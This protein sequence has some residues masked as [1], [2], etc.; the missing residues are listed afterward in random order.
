MD[1]LFTDGSIVN[2]LFNVGLGE[3]QISTFNSDLR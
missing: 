3:A 1:N 2:S